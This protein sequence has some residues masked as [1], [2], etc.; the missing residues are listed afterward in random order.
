[1]EPFGDPGWPG[2]RDPSDPVLWMG[3]GLVGNWG[4]GQVLRLTH[5][6]TISFGST[7]VMPKQ[8]SEKARGPGWPAVALTPA[9]WLS[10]AP[11]GSSIVTRDPSPLSQ[12]LRWALGDL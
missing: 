8:D 10:Y 7:S 3:T 4:S 2:A 6:E 1:M 9:G 12:T 11:L 5:R